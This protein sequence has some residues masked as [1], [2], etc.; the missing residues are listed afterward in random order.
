MFLP[1]ALD[2]LIKFS[3]FDLKSYSW[4]I[5]WLPCVPCLCWVL[6]WVHTLTYILKNNF[7]LAKCHI[8]FNYPHHDDVIKWKHFPR[9]WPF[10]RGIHRL[11][12]NSRQKSQW[13]G[14]LIFS[15]IWAWTNSWAN[16]GDAGDLRRR[17]AHYDAIVMYPHS[18]TNLPSIHQ[19]M[20]S[21]RPTSCFRI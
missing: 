12:V 3:C 6:G 1:T 21:N 11:P 19:R 7:G 10:V 15:L 18:F 16:N 2:Y 8:I 5:I 14:T 20:R 4:A 9:Y 13:W 17:R